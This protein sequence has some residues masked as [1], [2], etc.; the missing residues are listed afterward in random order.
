MQIIRLRSAEKEIY[1]FSVL[2][3]QPYD[4]LA[5]GR[6]CITKIGSGAKRRNHKVEIPTLWF[7]RGGLAASDVKFLFSSEHFSKCT[8]TCQWA[9]AVRYTR[10]AIAIPS[11]SSRSEV[12]V[13]PERRSRYMV[14]CV[15][16]GVATR[17][18]SRMGHRGPE[19]IRA[20]GKCRCWA[21]SRQSEIIRLAFQPYD[22]LGAL[23]THFLWYKT[24]V[25]HANHKV[26]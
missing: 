4:L 13:L 10:P 26:A 1:R 15:L 7:H 18:G 20:G 2:K 19:M 24:E 6:F 9:E 5:G 11:P 21:I 17:T 3:I 8:S 23:R 12:F 22:F 25:Q 14:A 16:F